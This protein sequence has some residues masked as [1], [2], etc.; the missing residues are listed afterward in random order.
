MKSQQHKHPSQKE[1]DTQ[2]FE[3]LNEDQK[4]D[5]RFFL[6]KQKTLDRVLEKNHCTVIS[7]PHP[8]HQQKD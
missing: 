2:D 3:N 8:P 7:P 4:R 5:F 6:T 1:Q